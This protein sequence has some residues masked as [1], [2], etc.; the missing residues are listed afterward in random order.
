MAAKLPAGIA[1]V[2]KYEIDGKFYDNRKDAERAM[3]ELN[4]KRQIERVFGTDEVKDFPQFEIH[5]R[6]MEEG[7][8][9]LV[10]ALSD[11]HL[12]RF[13]TKPEDKA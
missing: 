4:L 2:S 3:S 7:G 1:R 12:R 6:L 9:P 5:K 8:W 11:Y 13:R 10:S